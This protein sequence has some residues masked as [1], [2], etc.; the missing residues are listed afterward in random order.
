[1]DI[2]IYYLL[3]FD[4]KGE[5]VTS[6]CKLSFPFPPSWSGRVFLQAEDADLQSQ[7]YCE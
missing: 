6:A 5:K 3:Y 1:M 7:F 4:S 2:F